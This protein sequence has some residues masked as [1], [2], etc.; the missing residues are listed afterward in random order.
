MN[1]E[2]TW[3]HC[4]CSVAMFILGPPIGQ[5]RSKRQELA[6]TLVWKEC[7]RQDKLQQFDK[8]PRLV[9]MQHLICQTDWSM[10]LFTLFLPASLSL[11][12]LF[13]YRTEKDWVFVQLKTWR[14][15]SLHQAPAVTAL[16][17]LLVSC[18]HVSSSCFLLP[19]RLLLRG[20]VGAHQ[21]PTLGWPISGN[22]SKSERES[23][24]PESMQIKNQN[25]K[26]SMLKN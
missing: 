6:P 16:A 5:H 9:S 1:T 20:G 22:N 25:D 7:E 10:V 13:L 3:P 23:F 21:F 12:M 4:K 8:E 11:Q 2:M 19:F 26:E 14:A 24:C 18:L 17:C 15:L